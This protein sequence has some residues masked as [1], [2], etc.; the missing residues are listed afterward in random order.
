MEKVS[1]IIAN[2]SKPA[3]V[4]GGWSP[5][6]APIIL[7]QPESVNATEKQIIDLNVRVAAI[8][9]ASY[10][11]YKNGNVITGA[12]DT[13]LFS[14][15]ANES[16]IYFKYTSTDDTGSYRVTI[17]NSSGSVTSKEAKLTVK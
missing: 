9:E 2:Y 16:G 12:T 3:Y 14:V 4:L 1:E 8:P 13:D 10:Q 17:K 11:G 7:K 5:T 15:R 6:M